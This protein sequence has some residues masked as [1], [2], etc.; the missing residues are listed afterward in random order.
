[1][2]ISVLVF[3]HQ[4]DRNMMGKA[5]L[6]IRLFAAFVYSELLNVT[7]PWLA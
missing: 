6:C 2:A 7:G 4:V 1:M 3:S 5:L